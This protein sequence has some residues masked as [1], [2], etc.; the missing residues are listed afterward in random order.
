MLI[1]GGYNDTLLMFGLGAAFAG[2]RHQ[3]VV[4]KASWDNEWF[5]K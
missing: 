2:Y 3:P 5:I 4:F 1:P